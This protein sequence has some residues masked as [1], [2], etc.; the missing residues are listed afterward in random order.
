VAQLERFP[1]TYN[2]GYFIIRT[3][4]WLLALLVL[5]QALLEAV[6]PPADTPR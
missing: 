1:E 6:R 3:S 4:I 2:P 5:L